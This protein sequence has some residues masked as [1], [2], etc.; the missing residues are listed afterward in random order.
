MKTKIKY[1]SDNDFEKA[2]EIL[3]MKYVE[4]VCINEIYEEG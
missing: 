2:R 1:Y 4:I 3:N